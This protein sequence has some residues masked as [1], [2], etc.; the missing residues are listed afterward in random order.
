MDTYTYY[1][2]CMSVFWTK[3]KKVM[4]QYIETLD[5]TG[6][7]IDEGVRKLCT[8]FK[9]PGEGQKIDRILQKFAERYCLQNEDT[10]R[11]AD[12][13]YILSYSIIMLNVNLYNRNVKTHMSKEQFMKNTL[14]AVPDPSLSPLLDS[15]YD[16]IAA[17]EILLE[18]SK[19]GAS[20]A[21]PSGE[22]FL[23]VF[24]FLNA[25]YSHNNQQYQQEQDYLQ[26]RN[27]IMARVHHEVNHINYSAMSKRSRKENMFY[28]PQPED[29]KAVQPMFSIC[30]LASLATFSVLLEDPQANVFDQLNLLASSRGK[31]VQSPKALS[32]Q[33]VGL[34][35]NGYRYGIKLASYLSMDVQAESY[36]NSLAGLTLLG[37]DKQMDQRNIEAIKTLLEI[38]K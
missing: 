29:A 34:C 16:R 26:Q 4:H 2:Q 22:G 5:F 11:Q 14:L 23:N 15:I 8:Y 1:M 7:E 9:L 31:E 17:N 25:M 18:N 33:L 30:W 24:S 27:K 13:A 32:E 3:N 35:L 12:D 28:E 38:A 19:S 36:V 37:T 10:F 21:G 20:S 6:L